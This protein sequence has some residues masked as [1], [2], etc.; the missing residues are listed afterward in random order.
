MNIETKNR[1]KRLACQWVMLYHYLHLKE[2]VDDAQWAAWFDKA[3]AGEP[4]DELDENRRRLWRVH[5]MYTNI[6]LPEILKDVLGAM[7]LAVTT[8]NPELDK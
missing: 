1:L 2:G 5:V 6:D 8:F 4:L 3:V 7:E